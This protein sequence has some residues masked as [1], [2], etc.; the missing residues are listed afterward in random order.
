MSAM[1]DQSN[2]KMN[3]AFEAQSIRM[4][5]LP[6]QSDISANARIE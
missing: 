4:G 6:V 1:K 2:G 5:Q 3:N